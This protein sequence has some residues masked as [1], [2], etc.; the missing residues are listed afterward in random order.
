MFHVSYPCLLGTKQ[1]QLQNLDL[2]AGF[3]GDEIVKLP[4]KCQYLIF[5]GGREQKQASTTTTN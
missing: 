1:L 5:W 4:L 2:W 3:W